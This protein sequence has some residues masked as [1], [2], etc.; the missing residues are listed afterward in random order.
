MSMLREPVEDGLVAVGMRE[1]SV[2]A[3]IQRIERPPAWCYRMILICS[4]VFV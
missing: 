2:D 1:A 3:A 4:M